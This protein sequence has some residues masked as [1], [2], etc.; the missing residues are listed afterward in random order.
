MKTIIIS[1]WTWKMW[2]YCAIKLAKEWNKVIVIWRN[3]IKLKKIWEFDNIIPIKLDF[4]NINDLNN[5]LNKIE[6]IDY[7]INFI[8]WTIYSNDYVSIENLETEKMNQIFLLNVSFWFNIINK[9]YNKINLNWKIINIWSISYK[10][11]LDNIFYNCS[12]LYLDKL[13]IFLSKEKYFK[14][15]KIKSHIIHPW[16]FIES[17]KASKIYKEINN[18]IENKTKKTRIIVN[19]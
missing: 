6:K 2:L 18:I 14:D 16:D 11:N 9:L 5:V 17:E 7:I 4:N 12:K 3:D 10:Y 1:W 19:N 8:W 13:T 15:K